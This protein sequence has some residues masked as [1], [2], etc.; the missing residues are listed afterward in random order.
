MKAEAMSHKK[1]HKPYSV[2]CTLYYTKDGG[3]PIEIL[4]GAVDIVPWEKARRGLAE[5]D[6]VF[7]RQK[8][9]DALMAHPRDI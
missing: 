5:V 8:D 1:K 2:P 6:G 7:I 4:I 9:F 3:K